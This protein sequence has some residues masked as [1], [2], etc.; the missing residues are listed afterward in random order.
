MTLLFNV[1][2]GLCIFAIGAVAAVGQ[3]DNATKCSVK[4]RE[5][6]HTEFYTGRLERIEGVL[7]LQI[8]ISDSRVNE[9]HLKLIAKK[10]KATFCKEDN[11]V[12]SIFVNK[13]TSR[14][15]NPSFNEARDAL[16]G[17]YVLKK[18]KHEEYISFVTIPD[19]F[20]NSK[21]RVRIDLNH[22]PGNGVEAAIMRLL[23]R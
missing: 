3:Q 9:N 13:A 6:K 8:S 17:E 20:G 1:M 11:I 15:F 2:C 5:L 23:E 4:E 22:Q 10:I 21:A 12:A 7:A 14:N 19:Y 18:D 16:R